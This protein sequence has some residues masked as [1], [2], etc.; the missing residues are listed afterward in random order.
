[1]NYGEF[2][3]GEGSRDTLVVTSL[4]EGGK[5][6]GYQLDDQKEMKLMNILSGA[7]PI[8]GKMPMGGDPSQQVPPASRF[9]LEGFTQIEFFGSFDFVGWIKE[10]QSANFRFLFSTLLYYG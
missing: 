5:V 6:E 8:A 3:S 2:V 9:E 7:Q 10:E 4:D 1:M